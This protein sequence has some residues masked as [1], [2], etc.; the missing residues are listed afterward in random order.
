VDVIQCMNQFGIN[1]IKSILNLEISSDF[2]LNSVDL[3]S[4]CSIKKLRQTSKSILRKILIFFEVPKYFSQIS[5]DFY[6]D[7]KF[8]LKKYKCLFLNGPDPPTP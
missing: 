7:W 4:K 3:W 8:V 6:V 1:S 2:D 5:I